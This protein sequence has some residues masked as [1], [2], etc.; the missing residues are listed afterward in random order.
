MMRREK[1]DLLVAAAAAVVCRPGFLSFDGDD[2]GVADK[3]GIPTVQPPP[4]PMPSRCPR[5]V[6]C[7]LNAARSAHVPGATQGHGRPLE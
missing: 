5:E 2:V 3:A 7:V 1:S 6:A 4:R